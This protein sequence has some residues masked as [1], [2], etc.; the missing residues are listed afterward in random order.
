MSESKKSRFANFKP[1]LTLI[2][3]S[4]TVPT[5][6]Y[7]IGANY[8]RGYIDSIGIS[9]GKS[10]DMFDVSAKLAYYFFYLIV[11]RILTIIFVGSLNNYTTL[12]EIAGTVVLTPLAVFII[13]ILWKYFQSLRK[14]KSIYTQQ[15]NEAKKGR[16]L[17]DVFITY[18]K[19]MLGF[20]GVAALVLYIPA[21]FIVV[22]AAWKTPV[23]LAYK[24]GFED[25]KNELYIISSYKNCSAPSSETYSC[26]RL[27]GENN[28]ILAEGIVLGILDGEYVIYSKYGI[29]TLN[30][31]LVRKRIR[32]YVDNS[33]L[34]RNNF[35]KHHSTTH[36]T[37]PPA[38]KE[39]APQSHTPSESAVLPA[40]TQQPVR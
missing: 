4:S 38:L 31:A 2:L 23:E 5:L 33:H 7:L 40:N 9:L 10:S 29:T 19:R 22:L 18:P 12:I 37:N 17:R 24:E 1:Y 39:S 34:S 15:E 14:S 36:P 20:I 32:L 16:D 30:R 21:I 28:N 13:D 6:A 11:D 25:G 35:K 27:L 8:Y 26:T 3:S